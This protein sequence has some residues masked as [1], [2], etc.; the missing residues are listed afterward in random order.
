MSRVGGAPGGPPPHST[1]PRPRPDGPRRPKTRVLELS[2]AP[3]SWGGVTP[4]RGRVEATG[5]ASSGLG[6]R[7]DIAGRDTTHTYSASRRN[8]SLVKEL[9]DRAAQGRAYG[10]LGNTHYLLGSFTEATTFHKEVSGVARLGAGAPGLPPGTQMLGWLCRAEGQ[11]HDHPGPCV[12]LLSA[13]PSLRNLETKRQRGAPTATWATPTSSWGASTWPPSTTSRQPPPPGQGEGGPREDMGGGAR[14]PGQGGASPPRGLPAW[15]PQGP[16][17]RGRGAL[18]RPAGATD[19]AQRDPPW[20]PGAASA[21]P[22]TCL[23]REGGLGSTSNAPALGGAE[24]WNPLLSWGDACRPAP[25]GRRCSC[26]GSSRTRQWRRRP[27]TA[28]ATRTRYY[29][30]TS[31]RRSTTSGT[32]SSPRSWPTGV[33][34]GP[35]AGHSSPLCL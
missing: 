22:P 27:A 6:G 1:H 11:P 12:C 29:K 19:G 9:G 16:R 32:C 10:N 5:S 13:W 31:A 28:W 21:C 3:P 25:P 4:G 17:V 2:T 14:T 7:R 8:L 30:T 34:R 18:C 35:Q 24:S 33:P 26:P 15:P 23:P 20:A